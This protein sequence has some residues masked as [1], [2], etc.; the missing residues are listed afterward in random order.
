MSKKN[1]M[2]GRDPVKRGMRTRAKEGDTPEKV[3]RAKAGK[4][5]LAKDMKQL[6]VRMEDELHELLRREAFEQDTSVSEIIRGLV[7]DHFKS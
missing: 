1:S 3:R 5:I 7:K 6:N 2:I 4:T